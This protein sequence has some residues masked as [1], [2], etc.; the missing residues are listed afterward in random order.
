ML[1]DFHWKPSIIAWAD[2]LLLIEGDIVHLPAPKNCFHK[3]RKCLPREHQNDECKVAIFLFLETNSTIR[4]T[5]V[6]AMW[7]LFF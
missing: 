6:D 2:L 7:S 3:G 4:T 1:N 5:P